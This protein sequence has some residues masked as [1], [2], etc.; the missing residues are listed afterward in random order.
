MSSQTIKKVQFFTARENDFINEGVR[1]NLTSVE[2]IAY[3]RQ[4]VAQLPLA[5]A[6]VV[7]LTHEFKDRLA[8]AIAGKELI[9]I[10]ETEKESA[11][12]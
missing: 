8:R 3:L 11:K 5:P 12:A 9:P 10:P 6:D 7:R 2:F 1:R 4:N